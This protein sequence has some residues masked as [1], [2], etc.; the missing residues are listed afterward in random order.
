MPAKIA[1]KKPMSPERIALI[2]QT[3]KY[4]KDWPTDKN[5]L[6]AEVLPGNDNRA[7][8]L[9]QVASEH[10]IPHFIEKGD[11]YVFAGVLL[12]KTEEEFPESLAV[13]LC[14]Y[15]RC[16]QLKRAVKDLVKKAETEYDLVDCENTQYLASE[17]LQPEHNGANFDEYILADLV[18]FDGEDTATWEFRASVYLLSDMLYNRQQV[19]MDQ[20]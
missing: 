8:R 9:A 14:L 5:P 19:L 7:S 15:V 12:R 1:T 16:R 3:G 20:D 10:M 11:P 18:P 4:I 13:N 17:L 6:F 2:E